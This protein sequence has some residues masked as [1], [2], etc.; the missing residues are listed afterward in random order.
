MN[1]SEPS[2]LDDLIPLRP[3]I[4]KEAK[5]IFRVFYWTTALVGGGHL[6]CALHYDDGTIFQRYGAFLI[7]AGLLAFALIRGWLTRQKGLQAISPY[8]HDYFSQYFGGVSI[9]YAIVRTVIWGYGD[10]LPF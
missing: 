6:F 1:D 5:V 4:P 10:L 8:E 3:E 7:A 2:D 9:F